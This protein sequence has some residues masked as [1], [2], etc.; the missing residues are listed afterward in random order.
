MQS[1][2]SPRNDHTLELTIQSTRGSREFS[3]PHQEKVAAVIREAVAAFGFAASDSFQLVR[4]SSRQE[5]LQPERTLESYHLTD[6]DVLILT[7][8]G[9]GV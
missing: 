2:T 3:F 8:L 1:S 4:A 9:S 6:G 5:P 7:D